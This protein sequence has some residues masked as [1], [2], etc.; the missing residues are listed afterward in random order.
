VTLNNTSIVNPTFSSLAS[1]TSG[2][3]RTGDSWLKPDVTAPG[4]SV[5][6]TLVGSG[7]KGTIM[8]GTS[9][10]SPHVAGVAALVKQA[11]PTWKQ[12]QE[13]KAAIVNTGNPSAIGGLLP[14][15]TSLAGTGLVQPVP[16]VNTNVIA[17]GDTA[18]ATLNFG[19]S[20]LNADFSQKKQIELR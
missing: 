14:Y 11:H 7:N 15:K 20:E 10:A 9:M 18:T 16:A 2:G 3:P 4:V 13:W 8:S 5:L 17:L 19:F 12:V 6:S 1:F